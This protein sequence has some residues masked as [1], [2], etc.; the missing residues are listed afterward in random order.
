MFEQFIDLHV[1]FLEAIEEMEAYPEKGMRAVIKKVYPY[2]HDPEDV[3]IVEFSFKEYDDY[4]KNLESHNYY[5]KNRKPT[6]TARESGFYNPVDTVYLDKQDFLNMKYFKTLL[7][8][9]SNLVME[10]IESGTKES[11]TNWI[12]NMVIKYRETL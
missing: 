11:Y 8:E 2:Q 4:N 7:S 5:D 3:I 12:E 1:E 6:L 10:Y 9:R